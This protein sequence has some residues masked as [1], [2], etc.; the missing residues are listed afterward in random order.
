MKAKEFA[1]KFGVSVEEMCRITELSRQGLNDIVSGKSQNPSK[2]KRLALHNLRNYAAIRHEQDI[3]KANE[4]F[5]NRI[6]MAE[7]FYVNYY[8]AEVGK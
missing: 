7:I 1:N 6:K 2:A 8:L 5:E 4:D 3:K